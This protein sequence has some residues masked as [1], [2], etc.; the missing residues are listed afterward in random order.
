L[1]IA[2][3]TSQTEPET[4]TKEP[5]AME[6]VTH[7]AYAVQQ[8]LDGYKAIIKHAIAHKHMFDKCIQVKLGEVIFAKG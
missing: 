5:T 7:I 4:A 8:H 1:G 6:A 2:I 3:N